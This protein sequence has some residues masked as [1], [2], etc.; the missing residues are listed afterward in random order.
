M[1]KTVE[2]LASDYYEEVVGNPGVSG[3]ECRNLGF[4]KGQKARF[5][6]RV[7][8]LHREREQLL[9][10]QAETVR[11]KK[12]EKLIEQKILDD[13]RQAT[14]RAATR[15]LD[16]GEQNNKYFYGVIKDREAQQ[17]IQSLKRASTGERLTH[18][19]EILQEARSFYQVL[20]TPDAIDLAA[21]NTLLE[22]IPED[23][24]LQ[25]AEADRLIE[26]PSID[27][28]LGLIDHTTKNKSPGLDGLP[29]EVYRYLCDKFPP[30]LLLL[31]QALTDT[32]CCIFP[33][34]WKQTRMVLLFKKEDPELLKN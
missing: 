12:L 32:L 25:D 15:W 13:T 20:C 27:S 4:T 14:L 22:K 26:P 19:G 23:A 2:F 21:V 6:A 3:A 7:S 1:D 29:F 17:T 18:M 9:G 31:Q 24:K 16:M 5:K 30:V 33:D 10:D 8:R 11:V 28:A 34:S